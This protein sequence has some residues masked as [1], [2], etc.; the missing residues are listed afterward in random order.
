M[1]GRLE[2]TEGSGGF[3][4]GIKPDIVSQMKALV[5]LVLDMKL[6]RDA[7]DG[8]QDYANCDE[9][10]TLSRVDASVCW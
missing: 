8:R 2:S 4:L 5:R 6:T 3:L 1:A 9:V 7:L 10:L